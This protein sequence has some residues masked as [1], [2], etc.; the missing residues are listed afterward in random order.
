MSEA[1]TENTSWKMFGG[2]KMMTKL[3]ALDDLMGE[4]QHDTFL[5]IKT[6]TCKCCGH[7]SPLISEYETT[8]HIAELVT[9]IVRSHKELDTYYGWTR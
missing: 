2:R 8:K 3:E 7:I 6:K 4:L 9:K 1:P 5:P